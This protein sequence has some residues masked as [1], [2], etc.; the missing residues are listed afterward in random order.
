MSHVT[1]FFVRYGFDLLCFIRLRRFPD[2][3]RVHRISVICDVSCFVFAMCV[4]SL[5]ISVR[6]CYC[7]QTE[8]K[9]CY[10]R[11]FVLVSYGGV[12][13]LEGEWRSCHM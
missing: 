5:W 8:W 10:M 1:D 4:V 11:W 9:S 6:V 7:L 12:L 2:V 13:M 3:C